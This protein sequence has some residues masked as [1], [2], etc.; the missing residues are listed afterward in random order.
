MESSRIS[1]KDLSE[2]FRK[3]DLLD[4]N[5]Q[6]LNFLEE[7]SAYKALII[8]IY[9]L[10]LRNFSGQIALMA[11]TATI[12]EESGSSFSPNFSS[13]LVAIVQI[14]G[15]IC[16]IFLVEKAG[17]KFL[18]VM[19][20][21]GCTLGV[22]VLGTFSYLKT[23]EYEIALDPRLQWIPLVSFS[24]AIFISNCGFMAIS[25]LYIAEISPRKVL[26]LISTVCLTLAW[27]YAF[28]ITKVSFQ[29]I[30]HHKNLLFLCIFQFLATMLLN[31][32]LHGTVLFFGGISLFGGITILI[33][34][35][36][37]QGKTFDEILR[38][39]EK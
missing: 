20:Y 36:E 9:T 13:I 31:W 14:L 30:Q 39:L 21:L 18:F 16:S 3:L 27:T 6:N 1:I 11:Y 10:F 24:F 33:F 37:T 17:R 8:G 34:F 15:N 12:F 4:I 5:T 2:F 19:S 38:I 29:N 28:V 35:P 25:F 26:P 32:G 7:K 22:A 23:H